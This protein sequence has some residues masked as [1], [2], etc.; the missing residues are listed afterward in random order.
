MEM[1]FGLQHK[2]EIVQVLDSFFLFKKNEKRKAHKCFLKMLDSRFK[3]FCLESS[4][5]GHE[6]RKAIVKEYDKNLFFL[7]F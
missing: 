7:C 6:Q 4:L 3:T 5:I 1:L 2:K